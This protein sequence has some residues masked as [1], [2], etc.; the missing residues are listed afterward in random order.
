MDDGRAP[1]SAVHLLTS[2]SWLTGTNSLSPL[3]YA[4]SRQSVSCAFIVRRLSPL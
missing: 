1:S 3:A 4:I 2:S